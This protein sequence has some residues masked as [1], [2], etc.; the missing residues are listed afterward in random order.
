MRAN[1]STGTFSRSIGIRGRDY[2]RG[3]P[4]PERSSDELA[5]S[6]RPISLTFFLLKT[7]ERLVNLHIKKG[8]LKDYPLNLMQ[9]AYLKGKSTG[10]LAKK[11]FALG[12]LRF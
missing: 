7:M 6:F 4:N 10:S 3:T 12:V 9:H 11:E 2:K 1:R 5:K 8:P